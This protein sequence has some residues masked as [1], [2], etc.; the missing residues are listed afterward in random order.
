MCYQNSYNFI[1]FGG[2]DYVFRSRMMGFIYNTIS[3]FK[4]KI[5]YWLHCLEQRSS[6]S[7]AFL[8]NIFFELHYF[9]KD[10]LFFLKK[11]LS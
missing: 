1:C 7:Y 2:G 8:K 9:F 4:N 6:L 3:K 10:V 11:S 5:K